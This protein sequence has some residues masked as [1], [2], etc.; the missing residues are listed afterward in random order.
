[1]ADAN[2]L[3]AALGDPSPWSVWVAVVDRN[4][5][6]HAFAPALLSK[7]SASDGVVGLAFGLGRP[8]AFTAAS[9]LRSRLRSAMALRV[10]ASLM[11]FLADDAG[12]SADDLVRLERTATTGVTAPTASV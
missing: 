11:R 7:Y 8:R 1:M 3:G 12:M 5:N 4:R 6:G 2:L 9:A 10:A